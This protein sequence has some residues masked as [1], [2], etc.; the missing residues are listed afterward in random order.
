MVPECGRSNDARSLDIF[1]TRDYSLVIVE[2]DSEKALWSFN[3]ALMAV[4]LLRI[5]W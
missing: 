4:G 5:V 3:E 2:H 1:H